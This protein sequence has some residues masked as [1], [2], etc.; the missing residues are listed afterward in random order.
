MKSFI[1]Y[2]PEEPRQAFVRKVM[3]DLIATSH[4]RWIDSERILGHPDWRQRRF[5]LTALLSIT[6]SPG[7][8]A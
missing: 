1:S 5:R 2:G 6:Q 7:P 8:T 3:A 4:D